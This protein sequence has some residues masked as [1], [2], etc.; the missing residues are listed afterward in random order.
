MY[1]NDVEN[2]C[3]LCIF[4]QAVKGIATHKKCALSGGFFPLKHS[5]QKFKYD[6]RKKKLQ[7]RKNFAQSGFV[8]SDFSLD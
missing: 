1:S 5:C 7:R 4:A 8:A 3:Q 6:I 2:I